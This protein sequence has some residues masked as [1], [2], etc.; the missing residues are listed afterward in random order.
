MYVCLV[1]FVRGVRRSTVTMALAYVAAAYSDASCQTLAGTPQT[2]TSGRM[3]L[4]PVL[5][6]KSG[7]QSHYV[8]ATKDGAPCSSPLPA[9]Q[10]YDELVLDQEAQ[11][12]PI[13]VI[14]M[15]KAVVA[16]LAQE[17]QRT[18]AVK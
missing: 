18:V 12:L 17:F 3:H 13:M 14:E 10:C 5:Q 16:S 11:V 1:V 15:N 6:C 7:Y 9:D 8:V 4:H 2:S